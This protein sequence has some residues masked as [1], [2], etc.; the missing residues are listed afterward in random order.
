MTSQQLHDQQLKKQ[1]TNLNLKGSKQKL[2][3]FLQKKKQPSN[4]LS[5]P[6]ELPAI[7][8]AMMRHSGLTREEAEE[9]A[10]MYGF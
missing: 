2:E 6:E 9:M 8:R 3:A 1:L 4:N 5:Q 7:E 10:T